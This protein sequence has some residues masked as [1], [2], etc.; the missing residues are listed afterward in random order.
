MQNMFLKKMVGVAAFLIAAC[1]SS[2]SQNFN[3]L[4]SKAPVD[5]TLVGRPVVGKIDKHPGEADY[6]SPFDL[7][8][9]ANIK[10]ELEYQPEDN[11]VKVSNRVGTEAIGSP[12]SMS[13]SEYNTYDFNRSVSNYWNE[14]MRA[15]KGAKGGLLDVNLNLGPAGAIFGEGGIS[16]KPQG[17]A[18]LSMGIKTTKTENNTLPPRLQKTTV[19]DFDEKI[20]MN[21]IGSVGDKIK[22]NLN[23]NTEATFDFDNTLNLNFNGKED[24]IIKKIEAGNVSLP[25]NGSLIRGSQSLFGF[26]TEMQF[27][28]LSVATVFSQQESQTETMNLQGG[29][30]TNEFEITADKYDANRHF[31]LT[32]F[33]AANYDTWLNNL[34]IILSGVTINRIEVWVTNKRGNYD[35]ARNVVA[36]SDLGEPSADKLQN[37]KWTAAGGQPRN[38]ANNLFAFLQGAG[39][40]FRNISNASGVLDGQG[41]SGGVDYEK[42]ENARKLDESEYFLN[43]QLGYIS[44]RTALNSDEVLGVA[45]EYSYN[46]VVYQVGEFSSDGVSPADAIAIKLIKGTNLTPKLKTWDLMMKNVYSLNAYQISNN[47]FKFNVQFEDNTKGTNINY[48]PETETSGELLLRIM[49]LDKLNTRNEPGPDGYFDWIEGVTIFSENG[50]IVFPKLQPFGKN[51]EDYLKK[52]GVSQEVIDKYTYPELYSQTLT[53]AQQLAEKNKFRLTGNYK[54]SSGAEIKLN[55]M[56]IPRGSVK[57]IAGGRTLTEG[58]DY[59]VDY[60]SG[61]LRILDQAIVESG[62]PVQVSMEN[63]G[64]FNLQKKTMLGTTLNYKFSDDLSV[65]G[66]LMHMYERPI[67]KKVTMGEDPI[68]NTVWGMNASWRT[69]APFLTRWIDKLPLI[70][71]KAPS[72]IS[73][74]AEVAQLIPGHAKT[75][76]TTG[77]VYIDDFEATK[78]G[79]DIRYYYDWYLA[80]TPSEFPE[81]KLNNNTN[82]GFNRAKLAWYT[83]DRIFQEN[84]SGYTPAHLAADAEQRS[85]HYVRAVNER[86]LFPN[87]ENAYGEP[88][89]MPVL[90]LAYYPDEKGPYNYDL[91][92]NTRTGKLNNPE[93]RWGG[94]MR[95]IDNPDFEAANIEYIEFWMMDPFIYN[96]SSEAG[97]ELVFNLGD[98]SEDILKDGRK[99]FENGLPV[100]GQNTDVEQTAWGN[101]SRKQSIVRAFDQNVTSRE[102]QDV[103]LDGLGDDDEKLK[104]SSYVSALNSLKGSVVNPSYIDSLINDPSQD[105]YQYFR[106]STLDE[107]KMGVL[108]RY[109]NYNNTQA[110]SPT[111]AMSNESY[112]TSASTLPDVEDINND[113]TLSDNE[114]YYEY[115]LK[116]KPNEMVIGKNYITDVRYEKVK[117]ENGKS[118]SVAWYQYKVPVYDY[119]NRVGSISDFKSIRFMRMY[120]KNF[121]QSVVLRMATLELVRG[122]WRNYRREINPLKANPSGKLEIESVNFEENSD[123]SPI[124]YILPPGVDRLIDPGQP[125]LRQLNEQ[126]MV[127]RVLN[128]APGDA[129][130]AYKNLSM[131][132]RQYKRMQLWVHAE[133]LTQNLAQY[134]DLEDGDLSIFVRI[135]ADYKNNYYEYDMPLK[136]T[137]ENSHY[138]EANPADREA[139]WPI[140]NRFDVPLSMFTDVKL[141]RNEQVRPSGSSITFADEF[142]IAVPDKPGHTALVRGNPS[143][144]DVKVIMIGVRSNKNRP[145][146]LRS[147]EVWINELRLT[148]F[149]ES[150]GWAGLANINMQLADLGNVSVAGSYSSAG[151]GG[152][153]QKVMQRQLEDISNIDMSTTLQMG[154]FFPEK[155]Q[156][157]L[158]VHYSYSK[159]SIRPKYNPLDEDILLS[160]ALERAPDAYT[161]DSIESMSVTSVTRKAFNLSNIRVGYTGE[162]KQF[163]DPANISANF[164]YNEIEKNSPTTVHDI[165][166][167]FRGGL[168]YTY[169]PEV[170][171][172]EPLRNIKALSNENLALI[173]DFNVNYYPRQVSFRTDMNRNY[174]EILLRDV[175][176]LGTMQPSVRKDWFWNRELSVGYDFSNALG[177]DFTSQSNAVIDEPMYDKNGNVLVLNRRL[178]PSEYEAWRDSVWSNIRKWGRAT[179]YHQSFD[180]RYSVPFS[181]L[182]ALNWVSAD[183]SYN[184]TFDWELG[185]APVSIE[186]VSVKLGNTVRNRQDMRVNGQLNLSGLYS[187]S[188]WLREVNTKFGRQ[189]ARSNLPKFTSVK[190][191]DKGIKMKKDVPSIIKHKLGSKEIN[192]RVFD[193]N[194][195]Q[196]LG[197]IK[198]LDDNTIEFTPKRDIKGGH[199]MATARVEDVNPLPELIAMQMARVLMGIKNISADYNQNNSFV[200]PGFGPEANGILGNVSNAPGWMFAL[201]SQDESIIQKA[202]ENKWLSTSS[203]LNTPYAQSRMEVFNIKTSLEPVNSL[204]IDL[205]GSWSKTKAK[206]AFYMYDNNDYSLFRQNVNLTESGTFSMTYNTFRTSFSKLRDMTTYGSDVFDAFLTNRTVVA[207]RLANQRAASRDAQVAG[208]DPTNHSGY[209]LNASEVLIPAFLAAYSKTDASKI[210]LSPF[211]SI[212][213]ILPNWRIRYDGFAKLPFFQKYFTR[214]TLDHSYRST[215]NVA[216]FTSNLNYN[217]NPNADNTGSFMIDKNGWSLDRNG[218]FISQYDIATVNISETFSPLIGVDIEWKNRVTTN[219]EL[220]RQR[221]ISL[222]LASN[223]IAE[224]GNNEVAFGMGYRW[225]N[226]GLIISSGNSRKQV[227]NDLTLKL[228]Y[229]LRD[230]KSLLRKIEE[231]YNQLQSGTKTMTF[232]FSADYVMSKALTMRMF[233]DRTYLQPYISTSYAT[234]N[235]NFGMSFRFSLT[236]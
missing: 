196:V 84:R 2:F 151:W 90:N 136:L 54:S 108:D 5:T 189:G 41:L 15:E 221:T 162:K 117:L 187:K 26:K 67:T 72:S 155:A 176:S 71:T 167:N 39:S 193:E 123:R 7:K 88:T 134:T 157:S 149:D 137:T 4:T 56:N 87:K 95:A 219:F 204:R 198:N 119:S 126:S 69:D 175:G 50:R 43:R 212:S 158:P 1:A 24:D 225:N 16:I 115:N 65:G 209:S 214:F 33:F 160:D 70:T 236:Q 37:T 174:N 208:Y 98:I 48:I 23:Y 218:N 153:D 104:F 200:L 171:P 215:Y 128:L 99:S 22:L 122:E 211:P 184:G 81:A 60:S 191:E 94:I 233:Y 89:I 228:E 172:F 222:N 13:F 36:F 181:K 192:L 179:L 77:A 86:D 124:N 177:F 182:P 58:S 34:P 18:E 74:N 125:Q 147:G 116:I 57:V 205:N 17:Y 101:V 30:T 178:Y 44:L 130:A 210:G 75:V 199:L 62:T 154:K 166:K 29:A 141:R 8:T 234:L 92:L 6:A 113:N 161:R 170:K 226:F 118:D 53:Q 78:I 202:H 235:A 21:V 85:N 66:T 102:Y 203:Q 142:P 148:D 61:Y 68:S 163:F 59:T 144:S 150:G 216:Q 207:Q 45:F 46:G 51:L 42:V 217:F 227:S 55:A 11:S 20:Q 40:G 169:S 186:G 28:K 223:Q 133:K 213:S 206:S 31:L 129:R 96:K 27:G 180:A 80:S 52:K 197:E 32:H 73:M 120:L 231:S 76:G 232:K 79:Y 131:D 138:D 121:K 103:G 83:I 49:G 164:A 190:F 183:A 220:R 188:A 12:S 140:Q 159:N 156:V 132:F 19:F 100:N 107:L 10:Q 195:R 165:S 105:D 82:Y 112:P 47:D 185:P 111:P 146:E 109:K 152:L 145:N 143:L 91:N 135:G 64:L 93:Q 229:S 3:N 139:V 224:M 168:G 14:R 25:L 63:Q 35:Q 173:R 127:L 97:G 106:G 110:N 230:N 9:P 194:E 114:S 201:G 38:S